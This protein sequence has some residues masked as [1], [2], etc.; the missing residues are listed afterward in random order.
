MFDQDDGSAEFVVDVEDE[1]A[2]VL[3][4]FDVH[5]RHG[6]V[7]QQQNRLGRECARQFHALLQPVRQASDRRLADVFD[8][9]EVDDV[10]DL[11]AVLDLFFLVGTPV[12]RLGQQRAVHLQ[13]AAGH[14]VVE[15]GHALE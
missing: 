12:K 10:L 14:D 4:L 8:L 15:H 2:H 3:F 6:L 13:V 9:Q 11:L 7:E 5:A 1:T